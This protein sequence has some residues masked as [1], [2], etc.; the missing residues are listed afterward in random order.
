MIT[1]MVAGYPRTPG[2]QDTEPLG[3]GVGLAPHDAA[4]RWPTLCLLAGLVGGLIFPLVV[5]RPGESRR[6]LRRAVLTVATGAGVLAT[7]AGLVQLAGPAGAAG[8]AVLLDT[9][10]GRL[11][12]ARELAVI[13]LTVL[14]GVLR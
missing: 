13:V 10:G 11:W 8:R 1:W 14:C 6:A 2:G 5:R 4:S 3:T 12:L 9:S 7:L